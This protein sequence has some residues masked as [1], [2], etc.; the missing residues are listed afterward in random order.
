ME[1]RLT[2]RTDDVLRPT[3]SPHP[4][5]PTRRFIAL[6][7]N[8]AS[9]SRA[10]QDQPHTGPGHSLQGRERKC[11][12]HPPNPL[13]PQK[14]VSLACRLADANIM[15]FSSCHS[16]GLSHA[17]SAVLVWA[18]RTDQEIGSAAVVV[19]LAP[20]SHPRSPSHLVPAQFSL[21]F[22]TFQGYYDS[23]SDSDELPPG[24]PAL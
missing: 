13:Q 21:F 3:A 1:C 18:R 19:D 14:R 6:Q 22:A 2:N 5:V 16:V 24:A 8:D 17:R 7:A 20:N 23:Q 4:S 9:S 15:P 12:T 10:G 11:T